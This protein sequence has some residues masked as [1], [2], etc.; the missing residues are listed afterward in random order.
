M[1]V[2]KSAVIDLTATPYTEGKKIWAQKRVQYRSALWTLQLIMLAFLIGIPIVPVLIALG[3][4]SSQFHLFSNLAYKVLNS[5][6][7]FMVT[8]YLFIDD[9]LTI[10]MWG[11]GKV[12]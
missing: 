5:L 6:P 7:N 9:M 3:V 4:L 11:K 12:L 2:K 8:T 1:N 10:I